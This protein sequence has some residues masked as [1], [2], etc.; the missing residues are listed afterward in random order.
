[1]AKFFFSDR[2]NL[3]QNFYMKKKRITEFFE[4]YYFILIALKKIDN[5]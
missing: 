5:N 3:L 1:M 4:K 2:F